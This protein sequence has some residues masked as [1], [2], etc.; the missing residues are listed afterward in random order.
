[1]TSP[2]FIF[3]SK[4]QCKNSKKIDTISMFPALLYEMVVLLYE[5]AEEWKHNDSF[6][7][8]KI[9]NI[10]AMDNGKKK[11]LSDE[12]NWFISTSTNLLF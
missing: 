11:H 8:I 10:N 3:V 5:S 7:R 9:S 6:S 4:I 1:M 12:N 2:T